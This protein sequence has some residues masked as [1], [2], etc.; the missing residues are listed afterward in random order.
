MGQQSPHN[1]PTMAARKERSE[2]KDINDSGPQVPH[3][4]LSYPGKMQAFSQSHIDA[5]PIII[6]Y[7]WVETFYFGGKHRV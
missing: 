1:L 6:I 5:V 3:F 2:A 4:R 7:I